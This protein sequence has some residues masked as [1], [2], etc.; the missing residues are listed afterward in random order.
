VNTWN[1]RPNAF[2]AI[3]SPD[4]IQAARLGL[5]PQAFDAM[6]RMLSSYQGYSNGLPSNRDLGVFEYIGTHLSV[7]N[8][9]MLH[10]YHDTIRVFPAAPGNTFNG[11]FSLLAKGGFLVSSE[12][13][14]GETKYIGIKS[15]Y[16]KPSVVVNPWASQQVQ[17][18]KIADG[19]IATTTSAATISFTTE[20]D[21]VYVIERTTKPLGNFSFVQVTA[22]ANWSEKSLFGPRLGSGQGQPSDATNKNLRVQESLQRNR[23]SIICQRHGF[24][25]RIVGSGPYQVSIMTLS[26]RT[27]STISGRGDATYMLGRNIC[28]AGAVLVQVRDAAGSRTERMVLR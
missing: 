27:L 21:Q 1:S 18:R 16:G 13:E 8:E 26:G 15:L 9:S 28:G 7:M 3:W 25:L 17:V 14:A 23:I 20:A 22:T 24:A 12:I 5:G 2:S 19:S 4:G 11:K 6:K 10:S